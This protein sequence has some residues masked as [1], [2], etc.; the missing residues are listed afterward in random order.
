M[1]CPSFASSLS[2]VIILSFVCLALNRSGFAS[3]DA[4][5]PCGNKLRRFDHIS[6]YVD[7]P[8][9]IQS[10]DF[11]FFARLIVKGYQNSKSIYIECG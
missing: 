4:G 10:F 2:F 7:A 9:V 1:D 6:G 8:L 3:S 11:F 5:F